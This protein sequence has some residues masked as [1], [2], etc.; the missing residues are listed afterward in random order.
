MYTHILSPSAC[1]AASVL[2]CSSQTTSKL[3]G[4]TLPQILIHTNTHKNTRAQTG[5]LSHPRH[6]L[7]EHIRRHAERNTLTHTNGATGRAAV[8]LLR[9]HTHTHTHGVSLARVSLSVPEC[10]ETIPRRK[11]SSLPS[12]SVPCLGPYEAAG[13]KVPGVSAA[14]KQT[15]QPVKPSSNRAYLLSNSGALWFP[16]QL[17]VS[18]E[19]FVSA[20]EGKQRSEFGRKI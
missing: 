11:K 5:S 15:L 17:T 7:S 12:L 8:K 18:Y 9:S 4:I 3:D 2:L 1:L 14:V 6:V 19:P 16:S 10:P 20:G 13:P